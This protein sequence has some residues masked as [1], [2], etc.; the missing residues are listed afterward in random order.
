MKKI[1]LLPLFFLCFVTAVFAASPG[2]TTAYE[3]VKEYTDSNQTF[4]YVLSA[5]GEFITVFNDE[6]APWIRRKLDAGLTAEI[7]GALA[8]RL[9]IELNDKGFVSAATR[10]SAGARDVTNYDAIWVRDNVWVYYSFLSDPERRADAR[11][12]ILALWD[13]YSTPEQ[14]SRF[15]D[16]IAHPERATDAMTMPHI[17]FDGNSPGLSDV[18][19]DGK[20]EIWNHRQIDAHG[21]FFA[22]L[23]Q[24]LRDGLLNE[25]DLT[26]ARAVPIAL[27]PAFL[28]KI[29]FYAYEDAGSWEELPRKNTSSIGL[30]TRSLQ[31]L[32][33]LMY[34]AEP[35]TKPDGKTIR[36]KLQK[37][38]FSMGA[39]IKLSWS[40]N[41]LK[42]LSSLG[43]KTV[44]R[45]L[46]LGGESPDYN[47]ADIHFRL[48]DAAMLAL[49]QP[50]PLEGLNEDEM[51]RILDIVETLKRPAGV[52]RY[53]NDS[54]QGGNYWIAP[55]AAPGVDNPAL[56]GDTSSQNA[57]LQRLNKLTPD[58][59]AQWFFDSLMAM[60]RVHLA[61]VTTDPEKRRI[62][63][64]LAAIHIKRSL[65]QITAKG[66]TANGKNVDAWLAPESINTVVIDG[67]ER[68]LPSPIA[69]LNWAKAALASA[70][71]EY[72][73]VAEK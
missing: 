73:K 56:T 70:L 12:L 61:R 23:G 3:K 8:P 44:K 25:A 53:N 55:P 66:I 50:S 32:T 54:Y 20:P 13:Y 11:R 27:Y 45:Q 72:E 5:E 60:A 36:E 19:I 62:D 30:A 2:T 68:Y 40:L 49:I 63:I 29:R 69:P 65:G 22:A 33:D 26:E 31:V 18:T 24:A 57:F 47:P 42:E 46:A 14:I 6:V 15:K 16:I 59:E 21:I 9:R 4:K 48:A 28:A 1:L 34:G 7:R 71:R 17:R 37:A 10:S 35:G 39:E 51:R 41:S 52:L 67:R 64:H 58:T 38:I 43:L